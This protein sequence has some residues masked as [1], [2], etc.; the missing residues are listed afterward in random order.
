MKLIFN[1]FFL[2]F[3]VF[4]SAQ[5]PQDKQAIEEFKN[6]SDKSCQI[7]KSFLLAEF[8]LESDDLHSSQKWLDVTKNLNTYKQ[9]DTT[10]VFINSLQSELFYYNGLYQFGITEAEKVITNSLRLKDSL[11]ISNGY[12]F[13]AIN[14]LELKNLTETEKMLRKSRDFQ[15]ANYSRKHMRSSILKEHIYN[16]LAQLKLQLKQSD[17]AMWYN[18]RAYEFAKKTGSKRGIPN[19]EQTFG[20]IFLDKNKTDEAIFYLKKSNSSAEKSNYFDIVLINYGFL[21]N[22]YPADRNEVNSLFNKGLE[23]IEQKKINISFQVNFYQ[24]AIKAFK[25]NGDLEQLAF[26][27]KQLIRINEKISLSNNDY[28]QNIT[29]QYVKNENKLLRQELNLTKSIKEKQIFYILVGTLIL[30]T[31]GLWYFFKQRQKFKNKEIESLKQNQEIS[32]LEALMDGEEKERK[33]I[34]QELHDG[35]NG[36]LSAI[37]YRL[38]T[39]EDSGL[40]AVDTENITKVIDMIDESC[41]QVRS[42]SHNLMPASILDYG[43]VDS[44]REYCI[45]INNSENFKIDFQVFGNY[46]ALSKKNETVVYRIVQELITNILKHSKATEAIIQFNCKE[47]ELFITVED[48]GI[49]FDHHKISDGIGQKNIQTR[50]DF[51]N[52]QY[53][54]ISTASGTSCTISIDLKSIK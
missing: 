30:I 1:L 14:L 26:A 29:K 13:K 25:S 24:S 48:N 51:L 20:L 38:S 7:K 3:L 8:Y 16:N 41:A 23:L 9:L 2:F 27:Q 43:L 21:L 31:I 45:K 42:I 47:D 54:V 11:L 18:S 12:L 52:A 22:C 10:D 33:R 17:S 19:I 28:I 15:P 4:G 44:I 5:T 32:N 39:L 40:N 53:H 35:L 46:I 36:D 49:G 37:K 50:I 6:C 34:A